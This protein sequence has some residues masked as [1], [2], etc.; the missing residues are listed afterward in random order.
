MKKTTQSKASLIL[1]FPLSYTASQVVAACK[2]AGVKVSAHYVYLARAEAKKKHATKPTTKN[3]CVLAAAAAQTSSDI[4]AI[5]AWAKML[6]HDAK[7]LE[8]R[9]ARMRNVAAAIRKL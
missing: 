4:D 9:A 7:K 2:K 5:E 6:E 8:E 3:T 1:S